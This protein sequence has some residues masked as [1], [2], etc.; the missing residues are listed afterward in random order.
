MFWREKRR[1]DG[2]PVG[3]GSP[4]PALAR[5]ILH[6]IVQGLVSEWVWAGKPTGVNL[7]S[8]PND[9]A[10]FN[11]NRQELKFLAH[12]E[13]PLKRVPE[14]SGGVGL[15]LLSLL[16]WGLNP[17]RGGRPSLKFT[18]MGETPPLQRNNHFLW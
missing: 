1:S 3:V 13:N 8:K 12:S 5:S 11:P 17:R 7:S 16:A 9:R 10:R 18:P 15:S 4:D 2:S 14:L 6:P